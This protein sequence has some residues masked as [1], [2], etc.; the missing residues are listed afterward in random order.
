MLLRWP[1]NS[2]NASGRYAG[3]PAD[4]ISQYVGFD[5]AALNG[6]Y[7]I[8]EAKRAAAQDETGNRYHE[9]D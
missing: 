8:A 7:R 5:Q 4:V 2:A 9:R 6:L 1:M 3:I